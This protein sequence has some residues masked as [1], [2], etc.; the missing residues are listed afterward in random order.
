MQNLEQQLQ[1]ALLECEQL[2]IENQKLRE[3]LSYHKINP[4]DIILQQ[5]TEITPPK[6]Q[7]IQLRINI[8]KELFKGRTDVFAVRWQSKNGKTGYSPAC[9][10][11]WHPT[12]CQ[13]PTIKC[14]N[15]QHREFFPLTDQVIFNHLSGEQTI[16]LYPILQD[17]TSWFLAV[18]FD[19]KSW[20][21]DVLAFITTCKELGVPAHIERSRSGNGCHVWVFFEQAIPA[22]VTRKLGNVLLSK[23]LEKRYEI[24]M[25]SFDRLFPSQDTLP[26]AGF[27]NLIA[28]PLQNVPRKNGNSVFVDE[29]FIP[30]PDQWDYLYRVKRMKFKEVNAI[31]KINTSNVV[32]ENIDKAKLPTKLTITLKNG[33]YIK[34]EGL[35]TS[36]INH[37]IQLATFKNPQYYKSQAKRLSTHGIPRNITCYDDTE[38]YL[39]LPRG[40]KDDLDK[41]LGKLSINFDFIDDTHMGSKISISFEGKLRVEQDQAVKT[42]LEHPIGILSATT[43]FGKTVVAAKLISERKIN[44][45]IIVHRNQL[46]DQWKKSLTQFLNIEEDQIGQIGGGKSKQT[47]NIDIATIQSLN[48]KGEVKDLISQYG[49]I[50]V[51]ECHHISAFSFEQVIKKANAKYIFGLTATPI[52]KDGLQPIMTMQLGPIRYKVDGKNQAKIRPFEHILLPRFTTFKSSLEANKKDIQSLY[53][54]LIHDEYRNRIIFDDVL[55]EIDNGAVPLILTERVEHAS[56]FESKFKGFV[57]NI[58]VLTGKLSTKERKAN[59]KR[60]EE[61]DDNEERLVIATGKYIGEGFDHTRLDTLFLV[62]PLSWKGTLQ[63]YVGRLHRLH[64]EKSIVKVFDYVDHKESILKT[65]FEKR[66]KGYQSMGY[67]TKETKSLPQS[68]SE[69]M[70]MF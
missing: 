5:K 34:K 21:K 48:Y 35:S 58:V 41:L 52:R 16:G 67:V 60:L 28:L 55:S 63:Q 4:D 53:K 57:K 30:Y 40:C 13:K 27:G 70:K 50:I 26:K 20:Q 12:L 68:K 18:D 38:E 33:L 3:L 42:L 46:I 66:M 54:E 19:K 32:K 10:N 47:E 69:Q 14:A 17:E 45:L 51:D 1:L 9:K 23:T 49:Q 44:T 31:I 56:Y 11:E 6:L 7:K 43:G 22:S 62:M 37:L 8:F 64:N 61:L 36:F 2:R 24:G 15:C 59:L 25:D 65:M 39:I 29:D